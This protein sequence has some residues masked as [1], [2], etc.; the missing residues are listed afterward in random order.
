ML[1]IHF[2]NFT[3]DNLSKCHGLDWDILFVQPYLM[4]SF[5]FLKKIM[6]TTHQCFICC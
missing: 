4:L 1:V 5:G 2:K 3:R 6:M